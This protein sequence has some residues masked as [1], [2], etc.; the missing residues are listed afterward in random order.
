MPQSSY[1]DED[2]EKIK[3]DLSDLKLSYEGTVLLVNEINANYK[4]KDGNLQTQIDE[5]KKYVEDNLKDISQ[6]LK[7]LASSQGKL[8][9][10]PVISSGGGGNY[11]EIINELK[12]NVKELEEKLDKFI[13]K[14]TS[15]KYT[16]S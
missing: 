5:L 11:D 12:D 9:A 13:E 15:R 8:R 2:I 3:K 1:K 6:K 7:D 10:Q 14:S 4:E 16:S